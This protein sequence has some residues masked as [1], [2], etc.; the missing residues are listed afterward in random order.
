MKTYSITREKFLSVNERNTLLRICKQRARRD[1]NENRKTWITR[2]ML[3]H[4][5]FNSG[6]RVSEIAALKIGD[7]KIDSEERYLIVQRGKCGKKRIIYLDENIVEHIREYLKLKKR[8]LADDISPESPFFAGRAGGIYSATALE[9]SFKKALK[10]A[11]LSNRFS[12][13]SARHTYAT[14]LLAK[15]NNI[16]FVQKQLGHASI[17]MTSLYADILPEQNQKLANAIL[18]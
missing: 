1:F 6:M 17:L 15:T 14:M 5:A 2:Y 4:L 18:K 12:I 13:H 7:V 8:F 3:V 11:N 9:I 16:R 10:Q